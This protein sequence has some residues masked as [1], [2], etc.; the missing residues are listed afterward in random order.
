MTFYCSLADARAAMNAQD[1][2]DDSLLLSLV[3]AVSARIDL[4]MASPTPAFAPYTEARE[5]EILYS[6]VD[7]GR[8]AFILPTTDKLL[9]LTSVSL[10]GSA[11]SSVAAFPVSRTPIEKIRRTDYCSWYENGTD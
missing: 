10:N 7:S 11:L 4:L 2:I 9:A 5:F 8:N 3:G 1:T 6:N